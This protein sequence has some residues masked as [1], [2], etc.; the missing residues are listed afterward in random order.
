MSLSTQ[1]IY[2]MFNDFMMDENV[3]SRDD[4]QKNINVSEER[5]EYMRTYMKVY[6]QKESEEERRRRLEKDR[7]A[8]KIRRELMSKVKEDKEFVLK[9]LRMRKWELRTKESNEA[10]IKRL[11][12]ELMR[13]SSRKNVVNRKVYEIGEDEEYEK[14]KRR[15][16][17]KRDVYNVNTM[18]FS[19]SVERRICNGNELRQKDEV[20]R[21]RTEARRFA[22]SQEF[23][24]NE[25]KYMATKFSSI[26]ID[27]DS[28]YNQFDNIN[29]WK[30]DLGIEPLLTIAWNIYMNFKRCPRTL[31]SGPR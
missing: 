3:K 7:M 14:E 20:C 15:K 9:K 21:K 29:S 19:K 18:D 1:C 30:E 25:L 31:H 4:E 6:R 2:F 22:R 16:K 8:T 10:Y 13:H 17:W 28:M 5:K 23:K 12:K 27:K 26:V 24:F 11:D